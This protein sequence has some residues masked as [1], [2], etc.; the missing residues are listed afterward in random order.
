MKVRQLVKFCLNHVPQ[1]W[2]TRIMSALYL[3]WAHT[4]IYWK[5]KTGSWE[6]DEDIQLFCFG[7]R[8]GI[9]TDF[10]E[11]KLPLSA[12]RY[13]IIVFLIWTMFLIFSSPIFPNTNTLFLSFLFTYTN[14]FGK[15]D[16]MA[17]FQKQKTFL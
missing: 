9:P 8:I 16:S 3:L 1:S 11:L 12:T 6:D 7:L 14:S 2:S 5:P 17:F 10:L 15:N 13:H 4:S